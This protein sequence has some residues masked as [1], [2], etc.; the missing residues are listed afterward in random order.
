MIII[1]DQIMLQV[2]S[3]LWSLYILDILLQITY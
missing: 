3:K 2:E 1:L